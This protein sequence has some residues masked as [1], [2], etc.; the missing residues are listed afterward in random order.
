MDI[1]LSL[2]KELTTLDE[3]KVLVNGPPEGE[4]LEETK[5]NFNLS[6]NS[7]PKLW[8]PLL[9][10]NSVKHDE[11]NVT[12]ETVPNGYD[13]DYTCHQEMKTSWTKVRKLEFPNNAKIPNVERLGLSNPGQETTRHDSRCPLTKST[14][15]HYSCLKPEK[16]TE[17]KM[18]CFW[19]Q[20]KERRPH[21]QLW[22][23]SSLWLLT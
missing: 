6:D 17:R 18:L 1:A 19:H 20:K 11:Q 10:E 21:T 23:V 12:I 15:E 8:Y 2:H 22:G 4:E 5:K 13:I 14:L 9:W 3:V 7:V 16:V